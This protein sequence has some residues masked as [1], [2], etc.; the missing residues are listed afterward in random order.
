MTKMSFPI[1][2]GAAQYTQPKTIHEPL[3]PLNLMFKTSRMAISDTGVNNLKD[4]IDTIYVVNI[5]GWSYKDAPGEL[6]KLLDINPIR[7]IYLPSGGESPQMLVNRAAKEI[8]SGKSQVILITGGEAAYSAYRAETGKITLNWPR[9]RTPKYMETSLWDGTNAFENKYGLWIPSC[10]YAI[11]ETAIRA[12]SRR[13]V[14]KHKQHMG[15]I[16]EHYSKIASKNPYAWTQ[17]SYTAE[18]ITTPSPEN[19]KVAY[20]YTKRMCSNQF[21]DQSGA[22]I[23][24]SEDIASELNIDKNRWVYLMGSADLRNIFNI[25]QRPQLHNSPAAREGAKLALEQAGLRLEEID[26][27]DIYSCFPSIVQI[28]RKEIGLS[29]NDSRDLT[30]AGGL[31]YFGG[32]MSNYSMHSIITSVDLIRKN[33]LLKIMVVAN[34]GYN[35][36][37]SFGIYG[38]NPPIKLWDTRKEEKIQKSILSKALPNTI[39]KANGEL[40]IESYTIIYDRIGN[41]EHVIV[42][43]HLENNQRTIARVKGKPVNILKLEQNN[44][45][46]K[47]FPVYYDSKIDRN[48]INIDA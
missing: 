7:K 21:V 4:L 32:P 14:E 23:L 18:E 29:E 9:R 27:F 45:V 26:L 40:T 39:E 10:S 2:V 33:S 30:V 8:V 1:I 3:D 25:I 22:L 44:F 28:I 12:E 17:K 38:K 13:S 46:G 20:P 35:T 19:R 16:F 5:N 15:K 48:I 43:G 42:I 36:K 31:A 41:P 34:G 47:S 11:F 24:T 37:Q 6:S